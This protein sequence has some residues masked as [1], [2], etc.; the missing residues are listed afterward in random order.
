MTQAL[1]TSC[2]GLK[3]GTNQIN[4]VSNNV[5]NMNT[6]AY[7]AS[8]VNFE[9]I[10]Y[11]DL[12]PSSTASVTSGGINARQVGHGVQIGGITKNLTQGTYKET[13]RVQDMMIDGNG[14]FVV[15]DAEGR[16]FLT[17]DGSFT[18]DANGDMVTATGMYVMGAESVYSTTASSTRIHIPTLY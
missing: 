14:Y 4:V 15:G 2:T 6:T 17:R 16:P 5:A 9:T 11:S 13:G 18:L 12:S 7:K 3:A 1:Y 8:R 10:F